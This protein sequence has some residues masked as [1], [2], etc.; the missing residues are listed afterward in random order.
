M[1]KA[2]SPSRTLPLW[3]ASWPCTATPQ[4][5]YIVRVLVNIMWKPPLKY[6]VSA[7][8]SQ[9]QNWTT[10]TELFWD[11]PS[12]TK[13]TITLDLNVACKKLNSEALPLLSVGCSCGH[14]MI[15]WLS[16]LTTSMARKSRRSCTTGSH[17]QV[18]S[19]PGYTCMAYSKFTRNPFPL[20]KLFHALDH[21]PTSFTCT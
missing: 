8:V 17:L 5:I 11:V 2:S 4:T 6:L 10:A 9:R 20:G 1:S 13:S 16:F 7:T 12:C 3:P 18:P 14:E 15:K 21:P 19:P